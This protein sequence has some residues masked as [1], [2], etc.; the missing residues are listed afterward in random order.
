MNDG[1]SVS[2]E[3]TG[4]YDENWFLTHI[5]GGGRVAHVG[6]LAV[7]LARTALEQ[8]RRD[9]AVEDE[10]AVVQ[11][12]ACVEDEIL[13]KSRLTL[14]LLA[15]MPEGKESSGGGEDG[16]EGREREELTLDGFVPPRLPLRDPTISHDG[17]VIISLLWTLLSPKPRSGERWTSEPGTWLWLWRR[18]SVRSLLCRIEPARELQRWVCL[19]RRRTGSSRPAQ[20]PLLTLSVQ[21]ERGLIVVVSC[22]SCGTL[23]VWL[24]VLQIVVRHVVLLLIVG[25]VLSSGV[26]GGA[27]ADKRPALMVVVLR[28]PVCEVSGCRWV[29]PRGFVP[30]LIRRGRK[31]ILQ[32]LV[33]QGV[34]AVIVGL[35][36]LSEAVPGARRR[37]CPWQ[38]RIVPSI[39]V[40]ARHSILPC[41]WQRVSLSAL[42]EE[43][44]RG[45]AWLWRCCCAEASD[46]RRGQLSVGERAT[47]G[48]AL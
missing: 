4:A 44:E 37:S 23:L 33:Q 1:R 20:A 14:A 3:I 25:M 48:A 32:L 13:C 26:R 16:G 34:G 40:I 38:V 12:D 18:R 45:L 22:S 7:V 11:L 43:L 31:G 27:C 30:E 9:L 8:F 21:E 42:A 39:R 41:V 10:I 28:G 24:L 5:A 46:R 2:L 47:S 29:R 19:P 17:V 35:L 15:S 6:K 36:L